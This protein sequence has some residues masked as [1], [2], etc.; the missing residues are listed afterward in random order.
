MKNKTVLITGASGGIGYDLSRIFAENGSD[1]VLV[2]RNETR[3]NAIKSRFES[4]YSIKVTILP[5]DLSLPNAAKEIRSETETRGIHVDILVNNAG[6]GDFGFFNEENLE[7]IT[8]M[9]NL[10]IVTLT[11]LTRLYLP[12]MIARK[13]GNIL[14][15]ASI[16][17][18]MPGPYMAVYYASKAYVKSF[19][20]A[21]ANELKGTGVIVTAVCPGL[22]KTGF[23]QRVGSEQANASK[24]R[25]MASSESVAMAAV[26]A[27]N[28]GR[29]SVVP[30]FFNSSIAATSKLLPDGMKS[31][32]IRMIQEFNRKKIV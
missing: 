3:L 6:V 9:L 12:E 14:N 30:G 1:L 32:I 20:N 18:Y 19:S 26:K 13:S 27:M 17:A 22:T 31:Q 7:N 16:A 25:L 24:L 29:N 5:K 10:N 4:Q 2:S 28:E 11:E 15:I 8:G 23:Q 21:I